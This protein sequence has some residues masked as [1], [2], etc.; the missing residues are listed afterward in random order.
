LNQSQH[1]KAWIVADRY[2][3]QV[4]LTW[5][6]WA[7]ILEFHPELEPFFDEIRRTVQTSQRR[8]DPCNP[9]KWFYVRWHLDGLE[10]WNNCIVVVVAFRPQSGRFVVTC[11]QDYIHER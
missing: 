4:Y 9:Y 2:G 6:R 1:G 5:E 11:Y 8:Q 3:N 10:P 7:H